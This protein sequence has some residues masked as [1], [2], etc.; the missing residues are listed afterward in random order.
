MK[1]NKSILLFLTSCLLFS[2]ESRASCGDCVEINGEKVWLKEVG[3]IYGDYDY[4]VL[5]DNRKVTIP[6]LAVP[7]MEIALVMG[8]PVYIHQYY[9]IYSL[10]AN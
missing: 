6:I 5:K 7:K 2:I 4:I 3:T 8:M 9:Y 1:L 10:I